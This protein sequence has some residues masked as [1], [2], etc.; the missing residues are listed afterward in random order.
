MIK[1]KIYAGK[2]VF[3]SEGKAKF[4]EKGI[5]LNPT[6]ELEA[7]LESLPE[8]ERIKEVKRGRPKVEVKK[9][10]EETIKTPVKKTDDKPK[11]VQKRKPRATKKSE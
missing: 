2:E 11:P 4:D 6:E 8:Y 1:T 10:V 7:L 9:E 3:T 5:L